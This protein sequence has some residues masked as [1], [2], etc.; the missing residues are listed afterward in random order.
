MNLVD[1]SL[2]DGDA[3]AVESQPPPQASPTTNDAAAA[4]AA[5]ARP[6]ARPPSL[7]RRVA[8]KA[9]VVTDSR[10]PR[11][12]SRGRANRSGRGSVCA[13]E[14]DSIALQIASHV[15]SVAELL[16]GNEDNFH[17]EFANDAIRIFQG[18]ATGQVSVSLLIFTSPRKI[19]RCHCTAHNI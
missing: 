5:A 18:I 1:G 8:D 17:V 4:A 14:R 12:I 15:A 11:A 3:A 10:L 9:S 7:K 16:E 13:I 2:K 19:R 6:T